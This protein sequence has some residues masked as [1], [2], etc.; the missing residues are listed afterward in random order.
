MQEHS[1]MPTDTFA[2]TLRTIAQTVILIT[3]AI[4]PLIFIPSVVAPTEYTKVLCIS[5]AVFFA[6]VLYSLSV[7]REGLFSMRVS[8]P[9]CALWLVFL[10]SL[11][12]SLLSGDFRDSFVGDMFSVHTSAFVGLLAVLASIA[13]AVSIEKMRVM[14]FY[15]GLIVSALILV[16]FHLVRLIFGFDILTFSVFTT[17]S[18]TPVGS[19]NDLA[20]FLGLVT[21]LSLVAL[22]QLPLTKPGRA[23]HLSVVGLSLVMLA[24]INFF[25]VWVVLGFMSLA[26]IMYT[27]TKDRFSE[28]PTQFIESSREQGGALWAALSVTFV[29]LL[30][31]I[32]GSFLSNWISQYSGI[33]YIEVRPSFEATADIARNVYTDNPFLGIGA[34]KFSDAWRL[35]KNEAVNTSVFWNT[36]FNAGNGYVTTFFVTTGVLGGVMWI[37]FL[38]LYFGLGIRRLFNAQTTDHIWYVI[39][40]SSFVSSVYIWGISFVYVP[41]ATMLII[42]ALTTG[43]AITAFTHIRPTEPRRILLE[44]NRRTGFVMIVGVMIMI[45]SSMSIM[46]MVA[47]HY[48]S[49]YAFNESVRATNAGEVI[50]SLEQKVITAFA[51]SSSDVFARR[52]GEYQL[53]RMN[54]L[55][56][57]SEPTEEQRQAFMSASEIGIDATRRALALDG[58]EPLNWITLGRVYGVLASVQVQD[59]DKAAIDAFTKAREFDPKNPLIPLEQAVVEARRGEFESAQRLISDAIALKP[60]YTDAFYLQSQIDIARGDV[61]AAIAST[62]SSITLEP[63][64]AARY[65][66]LGVLESAQNNVDDAIIAFERAVALDTNFA[67][68]RYLLAR[69]YDI[70]GRSADARAQLEVVLR[71]NP[72]NTDVRNLLQSLDAFG[73]LTPQNGVQATTVTEPTPT[74][75]ENGVVRTTQNPDTPLVNPVNTPPASDE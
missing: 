69:A 51:F 46:Y 32:G 61:P 40:I 30:F 26:L 41:G 27:L 38:F 42:A 74:V 37:A 3:S 9:L 23:I 29:S 60:N 65:Y 33:S 48:S 68:A 50:D 72:D 55:V 16:I 44:M 35:Y 45:V 5:I 63:T 11:A 17:S 8:Y 7:L 49:I 20:L 12:S 2:R 62:R 67:N 59:A 4:L 70:Q 56:N 21:M 58:T 24:V 28:K 73:T 6:V 47:R 31:I 13:A 39:A 10:V 52:I 18:A 43:I 36:D 25:M 66:Q 54:Q 57:L 34:N 19:L 75:D 71:L 14:Y 53:A 22:E 1:P 64:N 15:M